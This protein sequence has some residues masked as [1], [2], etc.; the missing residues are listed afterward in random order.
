MDDESWMG[1]NFFV[2]GII[3]SMHFFTYFNEDLVVS[4][5]EVI[6]GKQYAKTADAW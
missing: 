5:T 2:S 1:R 6:N 4:E 3:P